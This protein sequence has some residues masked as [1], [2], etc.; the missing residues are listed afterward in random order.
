MAASATP[1]AAE[2]AREP[3]SAGSDSGTGLAPAA[4]QP[5][6]PPR[7]AVAYSGG[8]DSTALLHATARACAA[9]GL[10]VLA[11]HVHHGLSRHADD[12]VAHCRTQVAGWAAQGLPVTLSVHRL[13]GRPARG[14]SVE[15][16]ARTGRHAALQRLALAGGATLLLLA[17]HRRDQAETFVLQALRGAGSAGLAAM[18][19]AQRRAGVVWARPWLDRPREAIEAYVAA[20]GL[21]HIEDDSNSDPRHARNA[22]R[23]RVWPALGAAFPQAEAALA[24]SAEWAQQALAL[25]QELA[26]Q[27]LTL[28]RGAAGLHVAAWLGLSP[29]RAAN[30][31]R[32]WLHEVLGQ[33]APASLVRRLLAELTAAR[34]EPVAQW[35]AP[36]GRL[37]LY[38]GELRWERTPA[39]APPA[40]VAAQCLDLS[41]PGVHPLPALGGRLIVELLQ[42]GD[43]AAGEGVPASLLSKVDLRPREGSARF[44][45]HPHA[46]PRSLKKCWQ[47]AGV[48]PSGRAGPLLYLGE[49]L[50]Y[51]PG[52]GLDARVRA[53][54]GT[55]RLSLRWLPETA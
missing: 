9:Q 41:R 24:Q 47:T 32:A 14:E 42:A 44:Q 13:E 18:P 27:D 4:S 39:A 28:C 29:A 48:P 6:G 26:G 36:G 10:Q 40:V 11:L 52:L 43:S 2:R 23:L 1:R 51:V 12:W 35:P 25:Q 22:L 38:R 55:P 54:P 30:A 20:H 21:D 19:R 7:V 49:Q 8:R 46:V 16:W 15:A 31:L 53:C 50:L 34:D 3:G 45:P 17:H 5:P 33:P 37:R